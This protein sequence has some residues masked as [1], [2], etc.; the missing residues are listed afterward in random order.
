MNLNHFMF[1]VFSTVVIN[2]FKL[3]IDDIDL[4]ILKSPSTYP[5]LDTSLTLTTFESLSLLRK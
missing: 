4:S 3:P 1:F 2:S 5:S